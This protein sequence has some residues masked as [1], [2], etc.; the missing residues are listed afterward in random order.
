MHRPQHLLPGLVLASLLLAGCSVF[1]GHPVL[2]SQPRRTGPPSASPTGAAEPGPIPADDAGAVLFH[3]LEGVVEPLEQ[4][5]RQPVADARKPQ[6]VR[7]RQMELSVRKRYRRGG[8]GGAVRT[9][10]V[11]GVIGNMPLSPAQAADLITNADVERAVL[12]ADAMWRLS[13]VYAL[14]DARRERYR[15]HLLNRGQGPLRFDLRATVAFERRDSPDG[16]VLL[17]YDPDLEPRP[18]HITLFRGACILDPV[19]GG[20]RVTEILILGTDIQLLPFLQSE[21]VDMV[22][23]TMRDRATNLWVRAWAR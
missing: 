9:V 13:T 19:E 10:V 17:R 20:T 6:L 8:F 23:K 15:V 7:I 4:L 22:L 5:R 1:P 2:L 14:S 3:G 16:R 11:L 12:G 18:E 21:L